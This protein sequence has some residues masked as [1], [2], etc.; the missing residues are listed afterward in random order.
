MTSTGLFVV[1]GG[2]G[3]SG[4]DNSTLIR[5]GTQYQQLATRVLRGPAVCGH[6]MVADMNGGVILFGGRRAD[7][8]DSAEVWLLEKTGSDLP[9][10]QD[11]GWRCGSA[12]CEATAT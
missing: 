9:E 3:S 7:G 10:L 1:H 2:R 8:T 6:S 5:N 11:F 4:I 12:G